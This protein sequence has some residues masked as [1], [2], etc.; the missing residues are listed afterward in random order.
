MVM[1][2]NV[3]WIMK[4][5][6]YFSDPM[7]STLCLE[8]CHSCPVGKTLKHQSITRTSIHYIPHTGPKSIKL[9]WCACLCFGLRLILFENRH[10]FKRTTS[11]ILN[12]ITSKIMITWGRAETLGEGGPRQRCS[13]KWEQPGTHS[14]NCPLQIFLSKHIFIGPESDHWLCLSLTHSLTDSLT[15]SLSDNV[16]NW[17]VLDS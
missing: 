8:Q 12:M 10:H 11:I 3:I 5:Q 4:I 15:D 9:T 14:E 1:D 6:L 17:A 16:T 7:Q 2:R 13:P